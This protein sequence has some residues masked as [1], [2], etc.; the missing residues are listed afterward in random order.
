MPRFLLQPGD[1]LMS[2]PKEGL[3]RFEEALISVLP[4]ADRLRGYCL[5]ARC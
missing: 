2:R 4:S 5:T 1:L 3:P